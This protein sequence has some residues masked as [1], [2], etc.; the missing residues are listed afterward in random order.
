MSVSLCSLSSGSGGG[1]SWVANDKTASF[2]ATAGEGYFVNTTSAA[3]TV[4]LPSSPNA[5]DEVS[6]VDYAGTADTNEIIITSSDDING[7]VRDFVI[8]YERG[9]VS[10]VYVDFTQGWIAYNAVNETATAL[11]SDVVPVDYLVVAGGGGGGSFLATSSV[12]SGG[13]GG[14]GG[15]LTSFNDA[16]VASPELLRNTNYTI[17][18]GAGGNGG[19]YALNSVNGSNSVFNTITAAGGGRGGSYNGLDSGDGGSGGGAGYGNTA[20]SGNTPST[21]PSQGN[22]GGSMTVNS[23]NYG[24]GGGGGAGSAGGSF[25]S[26]TVAGAGGSGLSNAIT[27]TSSF[28]SGGGG[29]AI[30]FYPGTGGAGG[31]GVGGAGGDSSNYS[32]GNGTNGRGGG[33]G[34]HSGRSQNASG[35]AGSGGSGVV[36]LR[37]RNTYTITIGAGLTGSTTI[38]GN[39]K[40]TTF[41][42]GTGNISFS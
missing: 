21:T 41:T 15:Y 20:G 33:G 1:I 3:I 17:T 12:G 4:T 39:D 35:S 10:M 31:S 30:G 7:S 29:G 18:I 37:Y 22:N 38:D 11:A 2:T 42:A 23:A 26:G 28:Y 32:G 9:G 34:G 24:T 40:V 13:G 27:G 14:A 5:G 16:N 36:I 8:N 25:T 19:Q 6:I